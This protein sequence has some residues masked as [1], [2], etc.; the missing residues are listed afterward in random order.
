MPDRASLVNEVW[1]K[2]H[3]CTNMYEQHE[4][5]IQPKWQSVEQIAKTTCLTWAKCDGQC[6]QCLI[7][8]QT[9]YHV[10]SSRSPSES[11]DNHSHIVLHQC[12]TKCCCRCWQINFLLGKLARNWSFR[13][14]CCSCSSQDSSDCLGFVQCWFIAKG[15]DLQSQVAVKSQ[16]Q[17]LPAIVP[18]HHSPCTLWFP[19]SL[20][21]YLPFNPCCLR[22]HLPLLSLLFDWLLCFV[23]HFSKPNNMQLLHRI[24]WY[25]LLFLKCFPKLWWLDPIKTSG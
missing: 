14:R 16:G 12:L 2:W 19:I 7:S 8:S 18:R 13:M 24:V 3:S 6:R 20:G 5:H 1:C 15:S 23:L 17:T 9:G 10:C 21:V 25:C 4:P 11:W 22:A